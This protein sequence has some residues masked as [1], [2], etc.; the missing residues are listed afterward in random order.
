[1]GQLFTHGMYNLKN[2]EKSK[3]L[4]TQPDCGQGLCEEDDKYRYL[5]KSNFFVATK[6]PAFSL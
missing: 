1:M 5:S 4:F 6:S 2:V 3:L